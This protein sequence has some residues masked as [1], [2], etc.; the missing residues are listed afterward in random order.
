MFPS[1]LFLCG[2][3]QVLASEALAVK[4]LVGANAWSLF[5]DLAD[6]DDGGLP[7]LL[8]CITLLR[9]WAGPPIP[10]VSCLVSRFG[11]A[12][13]AC[14][15]KAPF[16]RSVARVEVDVTLDDGGHVVEWHQAACV[17]HRV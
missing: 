6:D 2:L 17:F 4:E 5:V 3:V 7:P 12:L 14:P 15:C 10:C 8:V 1:E 13:D 9:V 11:S 16:R